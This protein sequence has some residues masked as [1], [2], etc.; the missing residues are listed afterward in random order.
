MVK[1]FISYARDESYGQ[2]LA[3]ETQVQLEEAGIE[4][5]RD[6]TGLKGGDFW[7]QKLEQELRASDVVVL[8]LS[9]K[10]LSSKW[11]PNEINLAEELKIPV[12]PI[13]AEQVI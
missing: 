6:A 10:V 13:F 9:K 2:S 8:I 11:V 12:I 1:V 7:L 3:A 4:V 5:F